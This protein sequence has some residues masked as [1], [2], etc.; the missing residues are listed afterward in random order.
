MNP[1]ENPASSTS[2]AVRVLLLE[3]E[4]AFRSVVREVLELAGY[5]VLDA[6][7]PAE[8]RRVLDA[9][10]EPIRLLLSDV[11]M[12]GMNGPEFA[13]ELAL[14]RPAMRVLFMSGDSGGV[15]L[16]RRI[17]ESGARLLDKPF[18]PDAL[19]RALRAALDDPGEGGEPWSPRQA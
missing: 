4:D 17:G 15:D 14:S 2:G 1:S 8:G 18:A 16:R 10:P 7:C 5:D 6:S 11:V 19:L 13:A 3:D 9:H 12:P